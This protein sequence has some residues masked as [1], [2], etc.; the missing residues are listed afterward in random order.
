ML[1]FVVLQ[2]CILKDPFV[3]KTGFRRFFRSSEYVTL[4]THSHILSILKNYQHDFFCQKNLKFQRR[5]LTLFIGFRMVVVTPPNSQPF[6]KYLSFY[7][8]PTKKF[9][10]SINTSLLQ[11]WDQLLWYKSCW[12]F[13]RIKCI[14]ILCIMWWT[15]RETATISSKIA[16][17]FRSVKISL[18]K[19]TRTIWL[20]I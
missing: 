15:Q 12:H 9:F 10:I 20:S 16:F 4:L 7:L 5:K 14:M 19:L 3:L 2:K 17:E 1:G 18:L 11:L 6:H 8:L 13:I